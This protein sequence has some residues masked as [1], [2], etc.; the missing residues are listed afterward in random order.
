MNNKLVI[1]AA[2]SGKTT[3]I[4]EEAL[5]ITDRQVLITTYTEYNEEEIISKILEKRKAVPSNIKIQTWFSFLIQHGVK[6]Y[7]GTYNPIMFDHSVNG[8]LLVNK[9]SGAKTDK[10][11]KPV[12]WNG[13]P[14]YWGENENFQKHYFTND[15]RIFSDKLAKFAV[16]ANDAT[17]GDVIDR[18]S[19]LY[20]QIFI[21]EVQDLAGFDL[22]IVK[23]LFKSPSAVTLVGDPR[24][25]TYLTHHE[26]K[27]KKY[28]DGNIK[29]FC[30]TECKRLIKG[31]ID[32]TSLSVSHRNNQLICSYSS[33]LYPAFSTITECTC[34]SCR[35]VPN[36]HNG[37]F[38]VREAD[39]NS[40]LAEFHPTQLRWS[41]IIA[42]D[43]D[44]PV[45]NFGA[46]KGMTFERVL[47]YPTA[48]MKKWVENNG[49]AL[50]NEVRAKLYVG[51][52]RAR[53]SVGI[54]GEFTAALPDIQIYSPAGI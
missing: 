8:L 54:V 12:I 13:I 19:R 25:V 14:L 39:V 9:K 22:E 2:G 6:P 33:K 23:L 1:A 50:K 41:T 16:S 34:A 52:T 35:T 44:Y 11:G 53:Y 38:L 32:E 3:A 30:E 51:I 46:S 40:Y 5:K 18:I 29:E 37:I 49:S 45:A 42:T 10:F 43:P 47:I 27:Y 15:W 4:V 36:A 21:D 28:A 24:Q 20:P 48:D 7:Q 26:A 17:K 31:N